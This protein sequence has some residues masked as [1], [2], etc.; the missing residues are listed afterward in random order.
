MSGRS[1]QETPSTAFSRS[2]LSLP[3]GPGRTGD[4]GSRPWSPGSGRPFGYPAAAAEPTANSLDAIVRLYQ[5]NAQKWETTLANYAQTLFW[6]LAAIEMSY[7][8]IR[9]A[10]RGADVSEWMAELVNQ[11]LFIG[12]FLALLGQFKRLG[13]G[14]CR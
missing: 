8:A 13:Q 10:F 6:L 4:R 14:H 12:F 11:I 5:Q 2:P 9:L 1:R 7:A 3:A